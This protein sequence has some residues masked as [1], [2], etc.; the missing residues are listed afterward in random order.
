LTSTAMAAQR[1]GFPYGSRWGFRTPSP[2]F[3]RTAVEPL[4]PF[5][6][7]TQMT[8]AR[9]SS[10][11]ND[12]APSSTSS[13]PPQYPSAVPLQNAQEHNL[14]A[15]AV[16]NNSDNSPHIASE[17]PP[18]NPLDTLADIALLHGA[19]QLTSSHCIPPSHSPVLPTAGFRGPDYY[20]IGGATTIPVGPSNARRNSLHETNYGPI[21]YERRAHS[22]GRDIEF[23]HT[24]IPRR[25]SI[26]LSELLS[27][28][29]EPPLEY[30]EARGLPRGNAFSRSP[31]IGRSSTAVYSDQRSFPAASGADMRVNGFTPT[32]T[33]TSSSS[34][35]PL[36]TEDTTM[37]DQQTMQ[38]EQP[39]TP[40]QN[41]SKEDY[42]A[43][44]SA[45]TSLPTPTQED[46]V[47]AS[48]VTSGYDQS[49]KMETG[50]NLT[51]ECT[52]AENLAKASASNPSAVSILPSVQIPNTYKNQENKPRS[53]RSSSRMSRPP[54]IKKSTRKPKAKTGSNEPGSSLQPSGEEENCQ[55]CKVHYSQDDGRNGAWI[56][57]DGCK[58]WHHARCLQL[59]QATVDKIDK[60]YCVA[61]EPTHGKSTCEH[62]SFNG[63]RWILTY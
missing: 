61:C 53:R 28:Q 59:D 34:R 32:W 23:N 57:C 14:P 13:I 24:P 46:H 47:I 8:Y 52:E 50:T 49:E 31:E 9:E 37:D 1:E 43:L 38:A 58:G 35:M 51:P 29:E 21:G 48:S 7:S 19:G 22:T 36:V 33:K 6:T 30:S 2:D 15:Q 54:E 3:A 63:Y 45:S 62:P 40:V 25:P 27:P 17:I 5:P 39:L 18:S 4:S 56:G 12:N 42:L 20:H 55:T 44:D 60:F 11:S 41:Q 26:P 10:I 16:A